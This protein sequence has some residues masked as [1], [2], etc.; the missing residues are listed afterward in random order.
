VR[1]GALELEARGILEILRSAPR[2]DGARYSQ[3]AQYYR[4]NPFRPFRPAGSL[5]PAR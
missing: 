3:E 4:L 2:K 1:R 5:Q